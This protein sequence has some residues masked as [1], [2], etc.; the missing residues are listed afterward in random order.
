[1]RVQDRP[2]DSIVDAP[3]TL[4]TSTPE[5]VIPARA[6]EH[7]AQGLYR[8]GLAYGRFIYR[9]RWIVLA[10]WVIGLA[11]SI[12]FAAQVSSVLSGGGYSFS[13]SESIHANNI[14]SAKLHQ[15]AAT[16][17]VVFQS[18]NTPV[19]ALNYQQEINDFTT[20]AK[21]FPHVIGVYPGGVGKDGHTYFVT[22]AFN[23][24][25]DPVAQQLPALRKIIPTGGPATAY[26]TGGPAVDHAFSDITEE[27]TRTAEETALPIAL[28]V[29]IIVFGS[30]IAAALPLLM[31]LIAVPT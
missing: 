9:V 7:E 21:T 16:V 24:G 17:Q 12:P 8:I 1:M 5:H 31:A 13:G 20:A 29:L 4:T 26:I 28:L 18:A 27:D 30:L 15:P 2:Q 10:L 11:A 23:Q 19:T 3:D 22:L 6:A 25:Y 14:I